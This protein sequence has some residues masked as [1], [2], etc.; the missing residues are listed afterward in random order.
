MYSENNLVPNK[1]LYISLVRKS[2]AYSR[3]FVNGVFSILF[4]VKE[5]KVEPV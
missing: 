2:N 5:V 1:S 4:A 3:F